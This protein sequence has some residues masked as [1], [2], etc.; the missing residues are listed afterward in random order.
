M[1]LRLIE[2]GQTTVEFD[3]ATLVSG[4]GVLMEAERRLRR[5]G[6]N[7]WHMRHLATGMAIPKP[8]Q[9]LKLQIGWV[10]ET[11]AG[12]DPIPAD[13]ADDKYWPSA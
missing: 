6:Y 5:A 12:L 7:R 4:H 1:Y 13:Y 11:L 9:Y 3:A 10:A 8:L 2:S